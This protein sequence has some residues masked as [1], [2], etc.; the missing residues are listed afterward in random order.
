MLTYLITR[1]RKQ[2]EIER[3]FADFCAAH[4]PEN[5]QTLTEANCGEDRADK[6]QTGHVYI[7]GA[8]REQYHAHRPSGIVQIGDMALQGSKR[9]RKLTSP[10]PLSERKVA[11]SSPLCAW[12]WNHPNEV[13]EGL[14]KESEETGKIDAIRKLADSTRRSTGTK[15]S[16]SDQGSERAP[17]HLDPPEEAREDVHGA[18][19]D[20]QHVDDLA[21]AGPNSVLLQELPA[22]ARRRT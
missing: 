17:P 1:K 9:H 7:G 12:L 3:G 4:M 18:D 8:L 13:A 21:M 5:L 16:G 10:I 19:R 20:D 2:D 6:V 11:S 14:F 22:Q 15:S